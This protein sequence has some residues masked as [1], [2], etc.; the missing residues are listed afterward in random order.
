MIDE[1]LYSRYHKITL[2]NKK[3]TRQKIRGQIV[4]YSLTVNELFN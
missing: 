4:S 3:K 1:D 2:R